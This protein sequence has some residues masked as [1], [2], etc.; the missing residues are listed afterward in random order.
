MFNMKII[1]ASLV[2]ELLKLLY[3][4]KVLRPHYGLNREEQRAKKV[5]VSLTSYGRR[6]S[7]TLPYT[8]M[9]LLKQTYKP[10]RIVCWLDKDHWN[11]DNLPNKVKELE[12]FGVDIMFCEDF[13]SYKKLLP[14]VKMFPN[15]LIITVD[16]DLYYKS[17]LIETLINKHKQHPDAIQTF[18]TSTILFDKIS[19]TSKEYW[20]GEGHPEY[21]DFACGGSGTLYDIYLLHNDLTNYDLIQRL[22]PK[23]DDL[24]FFFMEMLNNTYVNMVADD[25]NK[26]CFYP[27]DS[28]YQKFHKD[29]SLNAENLHE[30]GNNIQL[31]SIM[32]YYGISVN[33][34]RQFSQS[35]PMFRK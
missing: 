25:K 18:R 7:A 8:L 16:D 5:I 31:K 17:T 29:G 1:I 28:F 4:L 9:S 32:D 10:D 15:D 35:N 11:R 19:N 12:A 27:I 3:K 26:T 22:A 6:V 34:L 30:M 13:K 14:S 24:W 20:F 2:G 21:Y 23:A 33:Q